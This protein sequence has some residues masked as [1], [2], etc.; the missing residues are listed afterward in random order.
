MIDW[1]HWGSRG[2][3]VVVRRGAEATSVRGG[4]ERP[5]WNSAQQAFIRP[6]PMTGLASATAGGSSQKVRTGPTEERS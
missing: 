1:A 2:V 5:L 6:M 4:G 3:E